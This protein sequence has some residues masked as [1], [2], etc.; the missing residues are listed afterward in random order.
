MTPY[1]EGESTDYLGDVFSERIYRALLI[2][3][4]I[5]YLKNTFNN[6]KFGEPFYPLKMR[7]TK[8]MCSLVSEPNS[9]INRFSPKL[10]IIESR[11]NYTVY[12]A[13]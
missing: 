7:T 9:T 2:S 12:F 4:N 13:I 3:A 10:I 5:I 8:A 6:I 1:T 11:S